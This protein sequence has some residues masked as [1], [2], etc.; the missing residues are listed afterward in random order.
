MGRESG[1]APPVDGAL[2]E[3]GKE[4]GESRAPGPVGL[5]VTTPEAMTKAV[6]FAKGPVRTALRTQNHIVQW[7]VTQPLEPASPTSKSRL[8]HVVAV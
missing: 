2:G 7:S 6:G 5:T 3:A 4:P 1:K 8:G